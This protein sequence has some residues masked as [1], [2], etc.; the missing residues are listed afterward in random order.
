M[1]AALLKIHRA[2]RRARRVRKKVVGTAA[3]PRLA[4]SRSH[5]HIQAQIIDDVTGRTLCAASTYPQDFRDQHGY[6]G[7]RRAAALVG[8][9]IG[10][11][12]K[13]LGIDQVCFDRRGRKYHGRIKALAEAAREAGLK[14]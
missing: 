9:L 14:F 4:V 5:R 3:R 10:E 1:K 8:Q 13:A 11:R 7:N 2:A 6:G 12:A